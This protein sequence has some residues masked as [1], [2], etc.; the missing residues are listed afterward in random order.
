MLSRAQREYF[1]HPSEPEAHAHL[2]QTHPA[3]NVRHGR[4]Q[5][6]LFPCA[7][8]KHII[9]HNNHLRNISEVIENDSAAAM[10]S[11]GRLCLQMS[12]NPHCRVRS[13]SRW[14]G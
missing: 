6:D 2:E 9:A 4:T 14:V 12:Y 13:P 3:K 10:K 7:A 11:G 5:D 8:S 1:N